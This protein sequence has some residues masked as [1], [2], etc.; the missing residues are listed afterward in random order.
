M[1]AVKRPYRSPLRQEEARRTR[2]RVARAALR[3]F[4]RRGFVETTVAEIARTSEVAAPTVYA[5]FG[6]K[7]GILLFLEEWLGSQ[8]QPSA[9]LDQVRSL[10][11][12]HRQLRVIMGF[13]RK[14]YQRLRDLIRVVRIAGAHPEVAPLWE[15]VHQRRRSFWGQMVLDW[16][17]RG[18]LRIP[19]QEAKD[20]LCSLV[21]SEVYW[22]FVVES[23]WSPQR[24]WRWLQG[25]IEMLILQ[26]RPSQ[27]P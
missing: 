1:A 27:L 13:Y 21:S 26:P 20:I 6:S 25:T 3:L 14:L 19:A 8:A 23:G 15:R 10:E 9:M 22:L 17:R 4:A 11:D 18:V 5:A 16:S 12:P 2:E 7:A 24:F